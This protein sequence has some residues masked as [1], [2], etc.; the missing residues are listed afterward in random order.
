MI[1][2]KDSNNAEIFKSFV[3]SNSTRDVAVIL[4]PGDYELSVN[5]LGSNNRPDGTYR[6]KGTKI[7]VPTNVSS[8]LSSF[9]DAGNL[10]FGVEAINYFPA[11]K[12]SSQ[13]FH[14]Y[15][16]NVPYAQNV[17]VVV[18]PYSQNINTTF[19]ILSEDQTHISKFYLYRENSLTHNLYLNPGKYYVRASCGQRAGEVYGLRVN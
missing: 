2:F 8:D 12:N 14:Y 10:A 17:S 11:N 15:T 4:D 3:R 7:S 9:D 19:E 5:F 6:V 13:L 1:C 18:K 16:F